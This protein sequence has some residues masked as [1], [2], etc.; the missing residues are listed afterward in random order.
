MKSR[1]SIEIKGLLEPKKLGASR[2]NP[3][4]SSN[5][6]S[7]STTVKPLKRSESSSTLRRTDTDISLIEDR[8]RLLEHN[9]RELLE[10]TRA[11]GELFRQQRE[12]LGRLRQAH[13]RDQKE[14]V[15]LRTLLEIARR[16]Q[17]PAQA[18]MQQS[19]LHSTK[20]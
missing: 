1:L 4:S 18:S 15:Q 19:Q 20:A 3:E 8:Y 10:E 2:Y 13:E 7:S 5:I 16:N 11:K 14:I 9:Y 6:T 12:E 17:L